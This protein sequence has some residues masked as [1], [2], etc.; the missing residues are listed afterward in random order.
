MGMAAIMLNVVEPFEQTELIWQTQGE[1]WWKLVKLCLPYMGMS[2]IFFN[3]AKL[4]EQIDNI[5]LQ[6]V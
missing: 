6:Q 5:P 3:E 2:A 4:F 1:I